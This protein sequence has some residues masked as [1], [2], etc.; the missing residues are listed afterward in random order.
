MGY[1]LY[2]VKQGNWFDPGNGFAKA[3]YDA[4]LETHPDSGWLY[5]DGES[6]TVKNPSKEQIIELVGI[7]REFGWS[8]QG[9]DGETYGNDGGP[10][11][12]E[13]DARERQGSPAPEPPPHK[14][15]IF[16]RIKAAAGEYLAGRRI[17]KSMEDISCPFKVGDRVRTAH[18]TG[19]VVIEVDPNGNSGL[20]SIKVRFPDG[21][22]LGSAF[23][24]HD[25]EME[26]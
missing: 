11:P 1:N 15:G 3:E 14:P 24:G 21:V 20:G 10:I 4:I 23:I 9:D 22:V 26:V 7:S 16:C 17:R 8:V 13:G 18:R 6:I 12:E 25:L 5:F 19:G 2:L